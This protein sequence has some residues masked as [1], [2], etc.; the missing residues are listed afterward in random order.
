LNGFFF[1]RSGSFACFC[2]QFFFSFYR[3][4][5]RVYPFAGDGTIFF[6]GDEFQNTVVNFIIS[7][8]FGN[9]RSISGEIK[10]KIIAFFMLFNF[11]GETFFPPFI[12]FSDNALMFNNNFFDSFDKLS[13]VFFD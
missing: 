6:D 1:C 4:N 9:K 3:G 2:F 11:V 12:D 5:F 10:K 7:F 13:D 8:Y